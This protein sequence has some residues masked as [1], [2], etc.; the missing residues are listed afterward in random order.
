MQTKKVRVQGKVYLVGA[1]PGDPDLLTLKAARILGTA[2]V[3]LHDALVSR[4]VLV[5]VAKDA[6]RIDVGKRCGRKLLTQEEINALL[7]SYTR[8]HEVVVRLKG[9]DPLIFGRA[10]EEIEAL[11]RAGV[12]FEIV[13]GITA[14]MGAAAAARISLTDRRVASQVLFTTAHRVG[15]GIEADWSRV[16]RTTTLVVYMPGADHTHVAQLLRDSGWPA[17]MP[18]AIVSAATSNHQKILRTNLAALPNEPA[19][20]APALLIVGR[21]ASQVF[22]EAG[23]D[24]WEEVAAREAQGESVPQQVF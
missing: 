16:T 23:K 3:V 19:L 7:I 8:A 17:E 18:C 21:V 1:G 2:D 24:F 11:R 12:D 5:L 6:E 13:P 15:D 4:E 20:P 14:A 10:G 22:Q 9:G